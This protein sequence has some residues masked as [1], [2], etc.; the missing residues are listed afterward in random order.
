MSPASCTAEKRCGL[1]IHVRLAL[2]SALAVA[3]AA[4]QTAFS[5][6]A[7][8]PWKLF[9]W[10]ETVL[11][12]RDE[13]G[14]SW[15]IFASVDKIINV[16]YRNPDPEIWKEVN[17]HFI[18]TLG[19]SVGFTLH[20]YDKSNNMLNISSTGAS[21]SAGDIKARFPASTCLHGAGLMHGEENAPGPAI[22]ITGNCVLT[23][24]SATLVFDSM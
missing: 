2:L 12:W 24:T 11:T 3:G 1:W 9:A 6:S 18:L 22:K 8:W 7:K 21:L 4:C 5:Q 23:T 15:L 19:S 17:W 14:A 13:P 16:A 20:V 10:P